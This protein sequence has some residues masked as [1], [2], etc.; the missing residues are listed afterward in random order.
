[1]VARECD[2]VFLL[3]GKEAQ[4]TAHGEGAPIAGSANVVEAPHPIHPR[5]LGSKPFSRVDR[6]LRELGRDEIDWILEA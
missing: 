3:M 1:M 6:R 5:F 2:P 4:Q